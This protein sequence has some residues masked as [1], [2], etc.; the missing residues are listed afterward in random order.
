M[1]STTVV[2]NENIIQEYREM[3]YALRSRI[4]TLEDMLMGSEE[5]I[6]E[7]EECG[8]SFSF[9]QKQCKACSTDEYVCVSCCQYP[10]AHHHHH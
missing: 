2:S 1:A 10:L 5:C 3:E 9:I 4:A 6:T 7:C 8:V